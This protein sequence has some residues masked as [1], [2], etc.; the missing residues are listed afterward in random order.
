MA[1]PQLPERLVTLL[2]SSSYAPLVGRTRSARLRFLPEIASLHSRDDLLRLVGLSRMDVRQI[3]KLLA[4]RGMRLRRI[5]ESVDAVI[6]TFDFRKRRRGLPKQE[7]ARGARP[8]N[9][10]SA[11]KP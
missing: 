1:E 9:G 4:A 6:C 2:L 10:G 5:G 11:G 3:E 7:T 8:R